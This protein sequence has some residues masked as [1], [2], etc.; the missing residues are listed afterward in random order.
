MEFVYEM[1]KCFTVASVISIAMIDIINRIHDRVQS[2]VPFILSGASNMA[3]KLL[4]LKQK[5]TECHVVQFKR[6]YRQWAETIYIGETSV[7]GFAAYSY[8]CWFLLV[9]N[10][11]SHQ[12]GFRDGVLRRI[13]ALAQ[14][15][16]PILV[17]VSQR[18]SLKLLVCWGRGFEFR[19]GHGYLSFGFVLF[20]VGSSFCDWLITRSEGSYRVGVSNFVWSGNLINEAAESQAGLPRHR[21]KRGESNKRR[22]KIVRQEALQVVLFNLYC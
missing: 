10:L 18:L 8:T 19:W 20:C 14:G 9:W 15:I 11:A 1:L 3:H 6:F 16:Y 7:L 12:E 21:R 17:A 13:F 5:I 4:T 22:K 2:V